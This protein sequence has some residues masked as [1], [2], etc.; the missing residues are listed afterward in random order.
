MEVI[1]ASGN[2][3]R[4]AHAEFERQAAQGDLVRIELGSQLSI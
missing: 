2:A 1:A 3:P 4:L